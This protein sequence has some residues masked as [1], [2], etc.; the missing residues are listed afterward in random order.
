MRPAAA[1]VLLLA[2]IPLGCAGDDDDEGTGTGTVEIVVTD[3]ATGKPA[4]Q[5]EADRASRIK[6][7]IDTSDVVK[8]FPPTIVLEGDVREQRKG[9]P[10]RALLEW[11]QAF[12]FRDV[13]TVLALTSRDTIKAAGRR[14]LIRLVRLS[15]LQGIEI[16]D[17]SR[18][19]DVALVSVGLL[20]FSAPQ[21][22]P[23]PREPTGSQPATFTM[24]QEGGDWVYAETEF[25]AP[26]LEA[27]Q[28]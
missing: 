3:E 28:K 23:P 6:S 14:N 27:L 12:Q 4:A 10:G 20:N 15:G 18:Q 22:E 21:G 1:L 5:A 11:W 13:K 19:G 7:H 8:V 25:L 26:K 16:L 9:T 2:L 17:V 24:Q